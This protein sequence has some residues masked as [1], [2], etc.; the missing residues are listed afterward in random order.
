[1]TTS[2]HIYLITRGDDAGSNHTANAAILDAYRNGILK[3]TSVMAPC[4]AIQE[5]AEMLAGQS[6]L[7]CGLHCTITA[8]WDAV[9]WGPVL[10]PQDVP[11]LVDE[12]GHFFQTT[13]A[14]HEHGARA[15]EIMAELTAQLDRA[16]ALGFDI[17]YAD[18]HMGFGWVAEGL[19]DVFDAW[20]KGEGLVNARFFQDLP[21][22]QADSDL[23]AG[24]PAGRDPV[25]QLIAR[26]QAAGPGCYVVVGHPA[27]DNDEMRLLG[28]TG[29]PGDVIGPERD[30]QRRMFVDPRVIAYCREHG[31]QPA[32]YDEVS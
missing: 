14:L 30:W 11:S 22:V 6:G 15:D 12:R 5:A 4:A 10:P 13:R 1:M 27:Y 31:V 25:E 7:C 19:D 17:R 28:H 21:R 16:R 8:E 2:P 18:K 20:C 26:L 32:R 9:R 24:N 23:A 3:N 29:Y